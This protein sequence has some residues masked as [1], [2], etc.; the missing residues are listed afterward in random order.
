MTS[1]LVYAKGSGKAQER[2]RLDA[3]MAQVQNIVNC[4]VGCNVVT[5]LE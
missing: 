4:P 3:G 5:C 2:R 1:L